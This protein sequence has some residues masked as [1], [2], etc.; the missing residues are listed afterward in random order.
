MELAL[1][2]AP[3]VLPRLEHIAPQLVEKQLSVELESS[4]A[5]AVAGVVSDTTGVANI[6]SARAEIVAQYSAQKMSLGDL[7]KTNYSLFFVSLHLPLHRN[8]S[9]SKAVH[10]DNYFRMP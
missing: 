4:K 8:C 5:E 6:D 9:C 1:E 3:V 2:L 7:A 10:S